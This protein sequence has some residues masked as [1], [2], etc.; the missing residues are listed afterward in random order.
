MIVLPDAH[1]NEVNCEPKSVVGNRA[2]YFGKLIDCKGRQLVTELVA[3]APEIE[4]YIYTPSPA[5]LKSAN[6]KACEYLEHSQVYT[7][8]KRMNFLLLPVV[9]QD[10]PRDFSKYTS[11]LKLFEYMSAGGVI[12]ASDI[13]VLRELL[14]HGQTAFLVDNNPAD[15]LKAMKALMADPSLYRALSLGAITQAKEHTWVKR[16]RAVLRHLDEQSF[17]SIA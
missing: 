15:W 17:A 1:G 13:P 12:V 3:M 6:L 7:A 9:P 16:A 4:F 14:V 2:G 5:Q 10:H 8:M 11:P